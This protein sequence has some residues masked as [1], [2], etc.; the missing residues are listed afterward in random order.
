MDPGF[1]DGRPIIMAFA[2]GIR[3]FPGDPES[4]IDIVPWTTS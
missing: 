1:Q 3:E 2:K 4:L